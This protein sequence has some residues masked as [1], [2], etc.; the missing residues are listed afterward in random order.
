MRTTGSVPTRTKH[1]PLVVPGSYTGGMTDAGADSLDA[2]VT[3]ID[4]RPLRQQIAERFQEDI[5]SGEIKPGQAIVETEVAHRFGVS[6][7]PVREA[8][9]ILANQGLVVT[10]P[11]KGTFVRRFERRDVQEAYAMRT[12][13]ETFAVRRVFE[14]DT[15][16]VA[17]ELRRICDEMQAHA[18]AGDWRAVSEVD[19]RFHE[20]LIR[21]AD[22]RILERFWNDINFR[23]RQIM[24]LRN[25]K[26]DDIRQIVANHLPI[27]EAIEAGD[28]EAALARV[29]DHVATAGDLMMEN[30]LFDD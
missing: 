30:T 1:E 27:V 22:Q 26:N 11:Y 17:R 29:A 3:P 16:D 24:A 19:D 4:H 20:T 23:V 14:G 10:E 13:L 2:S 12:V 15:T 5:L 7:A 18:D 9:Q 6:R 21:A 25:L 8:L 28:E